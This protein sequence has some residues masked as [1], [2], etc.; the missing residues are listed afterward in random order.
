MNL[1]KTIRRER[2]TGDDVNI[3][4][5]MNLFLVLVPFLLLTAVFVRIAVLELSLPSLNQTSRQTK[6]QAQKPVVIILLAITPGGFEIKAPAMNLKPIR[7]KDDL[8]QFDVL[9][10]TLKSIKA[11]YPDTQEITIQPDDRVLYETIVKVMD[12]CRET[13]FPNISISG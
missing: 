7:L 10:K 5:V 4:P 12:A 6:P 8:Y 3:T 1:K 9:R 2:G 13:G 11:R